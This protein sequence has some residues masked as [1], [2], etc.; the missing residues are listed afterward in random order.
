MAEPVEAEGKTV[1][2]A[3]DAALARLGATEDEVEIR[4][5]T[6][7]GPRGILGRKIEPARVR[8]R[9]RD[10]RTPEDLAAIEEEEEVAAPSVPAPELKE[11]AAVGEDFLSGLLEAMALEG[12]VIS[13]VQGSS[14]VVEV[15]GPEMGLLIGKRGVTL[16]AVQDLVRAA[17]QRRTTTRPRVNV[18]I[19]GYRARQRARLERRARESAAKVRQSKRPQTLEAM[20]AFERKV[21]HDAL[22]RF[23]GVVTTSEGEEPNRR[24]VIR[25]K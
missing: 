15:N 6:E 22:A 23:G 8:V 19:E 7:G 10:E 18:D 4:I 11:Q 3:I 21:V 13:T 20:T 9:L 25:P 17:V 16:E 2:E 1:E 5:L 24:V 14:A 12:E